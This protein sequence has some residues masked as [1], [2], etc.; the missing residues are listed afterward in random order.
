MCEALISVPVNYAVVE[1]LAHWQAANDMAHDRPLFGV[2]LGSYEAVYDD[3]RLVN[4]EA[5]LGHAHNL[6]LNMLAETGIIGLAAFLAFW[7]LIF[8]LTWRC[9]RHPDLFSRSIAIGLLGCW[10]YIAVHCLFDNLY[11]NNLFFHIGVLLSV[12][13]ILY[14]QTTHSL[15]LE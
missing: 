7:L 10:T 3:Y 4:W 13:A 6:Y 1:R 12:L 5:P 14:R 8:T 9:R 11:V 15:K 2:G